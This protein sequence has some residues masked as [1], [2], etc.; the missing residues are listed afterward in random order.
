[1]HDLLPF[2]SA[3][4][5]ASVQ[6]QHTAAAVQRRNEGVIPSLIVCACALWALAN[7]TQFREATINNG[8]ATSTTQTEPN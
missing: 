5:R 3:A 4:V 6:Y 8:I 1:M 2:S 7:K